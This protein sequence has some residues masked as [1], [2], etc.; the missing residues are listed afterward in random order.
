[1]NIAFVSENAIWNTETR[2]HILQSIKMYSSIEKIIQ[3]NFLSFSRTRLNFFR[4]N[5][6]VPEYSIVNTELIECVTLRNLMIVD[7][8]Y[9]KNEKKKKT[10]SSIFTRKI[11]PS[12]CKGLFLRKKLTKKPIKISPINLTINGQCSP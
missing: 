3:K 10:C 9:L 4:G 7:T 11:I 2:T 6:F 1:M 5:R 12:N 8:K